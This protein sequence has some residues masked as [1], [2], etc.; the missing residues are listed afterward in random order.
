M[1]RGSS[2]FGLASERD[3]N[4][5]GVYPD[6]ISPCGKPAD[7]AGAKGKVALATMTALLSANVEQRKPQMLVMVQ[8]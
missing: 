3:Q 4:V 2:P 8:C 1:R 5:W 7:G 6:T